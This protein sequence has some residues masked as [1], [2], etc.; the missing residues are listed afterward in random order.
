MK[1]IV[2]ALVLVI[3]VI[4]SFAALSAPRVKAQTTSAKVL[5]Y[6]WYISPS[7]TQ[8]A[9]YIGDIIAVGEVENTGT[10]ALGTVSVAGLAYNSTDNAI[11]SAYAAL[12]GVPELLPGQKAPFYMDFFPQPGVSDITDPNWAN[13]VTNV[14]VQ[15]GA[16]VATN[17][18]LY[19]GLTIPAGSVNNYINSG[20]Y[21]VT[22]TVENSGDQTV[23]NVWVLVTYYNSAGTVVAMNCTDFLGT[24]GSL[25]PGNGET[26]TAVPT[27]NTAKLSSQ[28]TNYSMLVEY[29]PYT[30][31][32]VT[33]TPIAQGTSTPTPTSTSSSSTKNHSTQIN[34]LWMYGSV[35]AAVIIIVALVA[36]MLLRNR[37]K[38]DQ[39]GAPLPPPPPPPPPPP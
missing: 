23:G 14:T 34:S 10:T 12:I 1:K 39:S 36:L 11:C 31:S 21:T 3:L 35:A 32:S 38:N 30:G 18:T 29:D 22:G 16:Q 27:D 20:A 24:S 9:Q 19:A 2:T 4:G 28:I 5:S 7:N 6:S 33:P 25:T 8:L 26:F 17:Q 13:S 37:K 15:L